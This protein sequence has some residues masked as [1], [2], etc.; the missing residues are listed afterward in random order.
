M[1]IDSR[2]R[3][4]AAR[5][6]T[7]RRRRDAPLVRPDSAMTGRIGIGIGEV[8]SKF[9]FLNVLNDSDFYGKIKS[10]VPECIVEWP[11]GIGGDLA[12]FRQTLSEKFIQEEGQPEK[13][14]KFLK[15]LGFPYVSARPLARLA[16][17]VSSARLPLQL[18][19]NSA[20]TLR[21][22]KI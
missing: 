6:Q 11:I 15:T 4:Q 7:S 2:C 14:W 12:E 3:H 13:F 1:Q 19:A 8:D 22:C 21:F 9:Y 10:F 5:N 17:M 16:S 20:A 18:R